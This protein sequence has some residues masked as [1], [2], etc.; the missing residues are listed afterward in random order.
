VEYAWLE[1]K[2]GFWRFFS[3][4]MKKTKRQWDNL[5]L[6]L[7]ELQGEGWD[8]AALYYADLDPKFRAYGLFRYVH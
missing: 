1:Q 4:Q 2:K 3:K 7:E 8:I 6:A 5:N